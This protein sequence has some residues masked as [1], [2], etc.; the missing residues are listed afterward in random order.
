MIA[1]HT[2]KRKPS[3]AT[4]RISMQPSPAAKGAATMRQ[5]AMP[6]RRKRPR[7]RNTGAVRVRNPTTPCW[8][9]GAVRPSTGAASDDT[10][11]SPARCSAPGL[12]QTAA[13]WAPAVLGS[14][15]C[16]TAVPPRAA[17]LPCNR[18]RAM[19]GWGWP[20]CLGWRRWRPSARHWGRCCWRGVWHRPAAPALRC[21]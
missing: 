18:L 1:S 13:P 14:R 17:F 5:A 9:P 10:S 16:C 3:A 4:V 2:A 11:Q 20:N 8:P 12:H 7:P 21:C 19:R 6:C 15:P